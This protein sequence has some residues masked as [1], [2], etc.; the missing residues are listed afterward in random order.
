MQYTFGKRKRRRD[1]FNSALANQRSLFNLASTWRLLQ[2]QV[3]SSI[4]P[5]FLAERESRDREV[6]TQGSLPLVLSPLRCSARCSAV[7]LQPA[8]Q[9]SIYWRRSLFQNV[10][11]IAI[12]CLRK[13]LNAPR[14]SEHPPVRG[15]KSK[16]LGGIIGW[17]G[18]YGRLHEV[19]WGLL[20]HFDRQMLFPLC[21]WSTR[22]HS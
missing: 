12:N 17:S 3:V 9:R 8:T 6:H 13:N 4:M 11:G 18:S 5:L 20:G 16:R 14:H 2:I 19:A 10:C 1:R 22:D 15:K 7:S 21:F